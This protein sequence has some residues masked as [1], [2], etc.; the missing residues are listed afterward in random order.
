MKPRTGFQTFSPTM[1]HTTSI[2]TPLHRRKKGG[3]VYA[4]PR[5]YK[6]FS[7]APGLWRRLFKCKSTFW[8]YDTNILQYLSTTLFPDRKSTSM[9]YL[10]LPLACILTTII[11]PRSWSHTRMIS[12]Q[13]SR[14]LTYLISRIYSWLLGLL[15]WTPSQIRF[16]LSAVEEDGE[17]SLPVMTVI[18]LTV[19]RDSVTYN[20]TNSPLPPARL[21]TWIQ[22]CGG[23]H[24]WSF[25]TTQNPELHR[26][27]PL[28]NG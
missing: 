19:H 5:G 25:C 2:Y 28:S 26:H 8:P 9:R 12:P 21:R 3:R 18:T 20:R 11:I 13:Q 22:A 16:A 14:K 1:S 24:L 4:I 10:T 6:L 15:I 7:W 17:G 27:L 23:C